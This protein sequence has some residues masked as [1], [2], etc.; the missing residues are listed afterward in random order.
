ML[1]DGQ[2][3]VKYI[4]DMVRKL[5][6]VTEYSLSTISIL[7]DYPATPA[8]QLEFCSHYNDWIMGKLGLHFLQGQRF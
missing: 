3:R 4:I 2:E 1:T 6:R 7:P 5:G 8:V